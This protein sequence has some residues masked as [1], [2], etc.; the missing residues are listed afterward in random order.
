MQIQSFIGQKDKHKTHLAFTSWI[1]WFR[2]SVCMCVCVWC[3][4]QISVNVFPGFLRSWTCAKPWRMLKRLYSWS[5]CPQSSLKQPERLREPT[6]SPTHRVSRA[7]DPFSPG[8]RAETQRRCGPA[9][10]KKHRWRV[11]QETGPRKWCPPSPRCLWILCL[12]KKKNND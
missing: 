10:A 12:P 3:A 2:N 8:G 6:A 5:R 11:G 1:F 9:G 7:E 4:M